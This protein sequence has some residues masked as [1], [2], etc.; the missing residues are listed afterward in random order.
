MEGESIQAGEISH[1]SAVHPGV[2]QLIKCNFLGNW[3]HIYICNMHIYMHNC[4]FCATIVKRAQ[5]V[6]SVL[7]WVWFILCLVILV[8][9]I[10][11]GAIVRASLCVGEL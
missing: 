3:K 9:F 7:L 5:F 4:M 11:C 6:L 1:Q 8:W 10:L 2:S